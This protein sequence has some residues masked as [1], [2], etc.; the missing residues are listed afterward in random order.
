MFRERDTQDKRKVGL[1]LIEDGKALNNRTKAFERVKETAQ[2][3][4]FKRLDFRHTFSSYVVQSVL[5]AH[6]K[7]AVR[8]LKPKNE[9][10]V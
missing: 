5:P 10:T 8:R 9:P 1:Y 3:E 2:I 4:N 6:L 7:G